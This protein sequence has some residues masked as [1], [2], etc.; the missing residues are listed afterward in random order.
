MRFA[1]SPVPPDSCA[2]TGARLKPTRG[3]LEPYMPPRIAVPAFPPIRAGGRGGGRIGA[4]LRRR[5]RHLAAVLAIAAAAAAVAS[6]HGAPPRR[7][8]AAPHESGPTLAVA[9]RSP[10][11]HLVKAPVRIADPAAVALLHPGV[12][13][14]VL[15][16]ARLVASSVAV[17]AVPTGP[18]EP[19]ETPVVP[20]SA[21][22]GGGAL[23]V[24]AVPRRTAAALSG[25]AATS[26]LGVA[27]C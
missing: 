24:L 19:Q 25:A 8:P 4:A 17:V 21:G 2:P 11:D 6:A 22:N 27:L 23:I 3:S 16:G 18:I 12:R 14:D 13:V 7:D 9:R 15:A 10:A 1:N 5:R 20:E 26:P